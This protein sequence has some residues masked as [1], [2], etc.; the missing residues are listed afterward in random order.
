MPIY[1]YK[2]I[3]KSCEPSSGV[4]R[5]C[6]MEESRQLPICPLCNKPMPKQF[7]SMPSISWK[8]ISPSGERRTSSMGPCQR[9]DRRH[10]GWDSKTGQ[11]V[12]QP[13]YK[14][15]RKEIENHDN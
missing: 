2:C 7:M 12:L 3:S 11:K 10:A 13:V 5:F 4:E 14:G 9:A 1:D 6:S 8:Y 15:K